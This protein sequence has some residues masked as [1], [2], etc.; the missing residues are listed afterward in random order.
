MSRRVHKI[1]AFY[2]TQ[3]TGMLKVLEDLGADISKCYLCGTRIFCT[4]RPP[5][6]LWERWRAW[7]HREKFYDWN[8]SGISKKGVICDSMKCFIEAIYEDGES[9]APRRI[10]NGI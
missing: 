9:V 7:W 5:R 3:T 4:Q 1:P 8:I 10:Q 2:E 6:S